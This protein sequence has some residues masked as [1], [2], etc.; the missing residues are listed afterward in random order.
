MGIFI[1]KYKKDVHLLFI[2]KYKITAIAI[3]LITFFGRCSK[4]VDVRPPIT[5]TPSS[6][7]YSTDANAIGVMN[8]LYTQMSQDGVNTSLTSITIC[9]GLSADELILFKDVNDPI[10]LSYNNNS[11]TSN[12]TGPFDF[13]SNTYSNY[14]FTANSVIEGLRQSSGL[15][16]SVKK[17]LTGEALFIRAFAY[18]YLVNLY[19]DVP[20]VLN[21]DPALNSNI[22]RTA[23]SKIYEQIVDD[24]K[25]ARDS[26]ND[27]Y[28][29]ASLL[30]PTTERIVP[31]KYAAMALLSRVYLYTQKWSLVEAE[32]SEILANASLYDTVPLADVFLLNSKEVI[33]QLQSVSNSLSNTSDAYIF[34]L[35]ITGPNISPNRFYMSESLV[36]TFEDGD[37]RRNRW[38]DSV[39]V[40]GSVFHFPVKYKVNELFAPTTE[41]S[42]VF[43]IA[44]QYLNRAE[45]RAELGNYEGSLADLNI[46]R[47]RAGLEATVYTSKEQLLIDILH[48]RNVE[49]FTEWGHRWLDLKRTGLAD[50]VLTVVK[51]ADW[52]SNDKLYP[53]PLSEILKNPSLPGHQ[54]PG[55]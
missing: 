20:L 26:L 11:L 10:L 35:P 40:G 18:F 28:L 53:I 7:I 15:T 39:V 13:W 14:I 5:G 48:E 34:I 19:G 30:N 33:W 9:G 29:D 6:L 55:Y 42:V 54:N 52:Q 16:P 31:N 25:Q 2:G 23:S 8:G 51:G 24:L 4:L 21:T 17:Q 1:N 36:A 46:I 49:L 38:I 50:D 44:E 43:R 12:I 27:N 47:K 37:N 32:S 45:A 3:L 41:R 22:P